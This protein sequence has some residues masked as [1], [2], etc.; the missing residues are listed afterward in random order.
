MKLILDEMLKRTAKWLRVFGVDTAY[1][2]G[3]S[4]DKLIEQ[5][6]KEKRVIVTRDEKLLPALDKRKIKYVFVKDDHF[7]DQI[8]Q[9]KKEL[10]LRFTFPDKTRCPSCNSPLKLVGKDEVK[11]IV[12]DSVYKKHDKFWLCEKCNK[13]YWE[14]SHW[15]NITRIHEKCSSS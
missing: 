12:I 9:I 11:E 1:F 13:A 2:H 6:E 15:K 4:D 10:K 3:K 5:A 7:E 8:C 14:G